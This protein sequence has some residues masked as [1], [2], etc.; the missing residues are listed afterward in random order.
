PGLALRLFTR[1]FTR[2]RKVDTFRGKQVVLHRETAAP[3]HFDGDPIEMGTDI[4]IDIH[5]AA[6]RVLV[7]EGRSYKI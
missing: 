5:P 1:R 2:S 4:H 7:P 6:V 3:A